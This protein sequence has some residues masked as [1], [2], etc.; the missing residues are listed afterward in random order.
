LL[1]LLLPSAAPLAVPCILSSFINTQR[2]QCT[3]AA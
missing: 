3:F 1:L 2:G